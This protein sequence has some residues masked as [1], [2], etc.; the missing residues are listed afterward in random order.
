MMLVFDDFDLIWI[1]LIDVDNWF[2]LGDEI[3]VLNWFCYGF[4][5]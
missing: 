2:I 3:V 1:F 4:V 5:K